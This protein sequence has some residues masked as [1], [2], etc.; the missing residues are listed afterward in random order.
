M[1][2]YT[3]DIRKGRSVVRRS[4]SNVSSLQHIV[5]QE[6]DQCSNTELK[7]WN[8]S[9]RSYIVPR[10]VSV[11]SLGRSEAVANSFRH[12]AFV[13]LHSVLYHIT[14][15]QDS[16]VNLSEL[17]MLHTQI[18][19]TKAEAV[20]NTLATIERNFPLD[21]CEFS[22]L[23]FP[24]FVAGCETSRQEH[25]ATI[26]SA[27]NQLELNFGIGNTS[28]VKSVLDHIWGSKM[29]DG[30]GKHWYKVLRELGWEIL[31]S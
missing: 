9:S 8:V 16:D 28:R 3:F 17:Q 15:S 25:Y 22:A 27:V 13:Y 26:L 20:D 29:T 21:R 2:V 10:G 6:T 31:L 12:A 4:E 7:N 5:E 24:L 1:Q 30:G 23:C 11:A 18:S 19:Y 14:S